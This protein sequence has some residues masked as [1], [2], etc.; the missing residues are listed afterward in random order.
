MSNMMEKSINLGL[1]LFVYSRE[2]IEEMV[3]ELVKKGEVARKDAHEVARELIQ[4]GEEQ[5]KELKKLIK[6]QVADVLN[7]MNVAKKDD[8][9]TEDE[10]SRII[11][12]QLTQVINDQKQNN[13]KE[14]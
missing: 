9:P 7:E 5:K 11:K 6:D 10:I 4:K 8:I 3:E 14:M 1:G 13:K 12:D 2:K